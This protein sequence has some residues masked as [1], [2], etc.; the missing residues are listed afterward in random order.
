MFL[1]FD[2]KSLYPEIIVNLALHMFEFYNENTILYL[3]CAFNCAY[4]SIFDTYIHYTH[5]L[6]HSFCLLYSISLYNYIMIYLK[7]A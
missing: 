2:C 7:D 6:D 5:T 3:E 4:H 1:D